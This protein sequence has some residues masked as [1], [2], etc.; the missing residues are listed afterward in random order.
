MTH[1][2]LGVAELNMELLGWD[3][4][5]WEA[6]RQDDS[7][8]CSAVGKSSVPASGMCHTRFTPCLA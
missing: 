4:N 5:R 6:T 8:R 3:E 7:S 1:L 2:I